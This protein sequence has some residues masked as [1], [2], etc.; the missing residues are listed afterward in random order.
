MLM[1]CPECGHDMSSL[2]EACPN[3]GYKL[4]HKE[5]TQN[6][7]DNYQNV[8]NESYSN[9]A[10]TASAVIGG[11]LGYSLLRSL[12]RPRRRR[13]PMV[14]PAPHGPRGMGGPHGPGG[15]GRR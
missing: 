12:L 5:E 9:G 15:F 13:G 4:L 14:P 7:D 3:C 1:K 2:A 8:E 10:K 6:V 11:V